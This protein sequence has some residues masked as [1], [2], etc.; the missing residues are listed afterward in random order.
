MPGH[1]TNPCLA[2][3]IQGAGF[4]SLE[5]FAIAVNH[6]GWDMHG[7]KTCY[8][9]ISVK[10][11]LAGSVRQNPDVVAAVLSD[12][13]GV[14]VPVQVIWPELRDGTSPV[15]AHL[16]PWVAVR[17]LEDL[18]IFIRSDMLTRR[19]MLTEAIGL[20]TGSTFVEP[21]ARWLNARAVGPAA[22]GTERPDRIGMADVIGIER[23]TQYFAA[24]DAEAGGGLSREA[25]VGQLKYAVDLMHSASYTS[26]VGNRLLAAIADLSGWVGWMS[27]DVAMDGPAQ[28]YFVYGLQAAR[29]S[30]DERAQFRAVGILADMSRQMLASGRPD[31]GL[32]LIDLAFDQ[33]PRDGRRIN[34]V[35]SLLWNLRA[36]ML[37]SMGTGYTSEARSAV[38]LSFDLYG[39]IGDE[40]NASAVTA[41][42][43]YT[44]DAELASGAAVCY[45]LLDEHDRALA[46]EA[47][48]QALYALSHRPKGFT[49]SRVFDQIEL[50]R[51]RFAA[52]EPDQACTDGEV[53]LRLAGDVATS[54]RVVLRLH[55]LLEDAEPYK[56][57]NRVREMREKLRL[58]L[59]KQ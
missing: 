31:S 57:R 44:T 38:G 41:C 13:W 58:A 48:R 14:P 42:F 23:S 22:T 10:R 52:G 59:M 39:Q 46:A 43:P 19:E 56:N 34:K 36:H 45:R 18:G 28:R 8:D 7:I 53:A 32:R 2:A 25:A 17:T 21:I 5:R 6:R 47:E 29:E 20:A 27:H 4:A 51:A 40:D 30:H 9:H 12:G 11:W 50:A 37:A 1:I 33:L 15:P 16:Q 54:K 55:E 49:R 3:L 26:P 24:T 35:R